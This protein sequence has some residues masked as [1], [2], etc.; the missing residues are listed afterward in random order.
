MKALF[1]LLLFP[2]FAFSEVKPEPIEGLFQDLP[3]EERILKRMDLARDIV[4]GKEKKYEIKQAILLYAL[5]VKDK[6][7]HGQSWHEWINRIL[8]GGSLGPLAYT[9]EVMAKVAPMIRIALSKVP[10]HPGI[11]IVKLKLDFIKGAEN[12]KVKEGLEKLRI[13]SDQL[14]FSNL[15]S[16][17]QLYGAIKEPIPASDVFKR[18]EAKASTIEERYLVYQ[19]RGQ[20]AVASESWNDCAD[21]YQKAEE[22]L[23]QIIQIKVSIVGCLSKAKRFDEALSYES[24][25]GNVQEAN[26]HFSEAQIGKSQGLINS[27]KFDEAEALLNKSLKCPKWEAFEAL[28]KANVRKNNFD[29]AVEFLFKTLE[30][31][32]SDKSSFLRSWSDAFKPS[33]QHYQQLVLK[34][35]ELDSR[36]EIKVHSYYDLVKELM[37]SKNGEAKEMITTALAMGDSALAQNSE[38][39]EFLKYYGGLYGIS[40]INLG[41]AP[42]VTKAQMIFSKCKQLV[43]SG[44]AFVNAW[45]AQVG[46]PE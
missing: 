29:K 3:I 26:C 45:V 25:L 42:D 34:S 40:G 20:S 46:D 37:N 21:A 35:I 6:P 33:S 43:P 1:F 5:N 44:D 32:G 17:A 14:D 2:M 11:Q 12:Y 36:A 9:P 19:G 27:G 16:M 23:P 38:N 22:I 30:L 24:K 28:T 7:D 8:A 41:N 4:S 31:Y 13:K 18:M 15:Y 10:D 39:Y